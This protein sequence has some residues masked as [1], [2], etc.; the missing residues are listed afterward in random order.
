MDLSCSGYYI[1]TQ[2]KAQIVISMLCIDPSAL[3]S[4]IFSTLRAY[5]QLCRR[6]RHVHFAQKIS[7]LY[8]P[9]LFQ[10]THVLL[11]TP[12]QTSLLS[13]SACRIVTRTPST[14]THL[15][16]VAHPHDCVKPKLQ[17][18][19]NGIRLERS[20]RRF[21]SLLAQ[22]RLL[23]L[24]ATKK[25]LRRLVLIGHSQSLGEMGRM[26]SLSTGSVL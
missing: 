14:H 20:H 25:P 6:A 24:I 9:C 13:R 23:P 10:H 21:A 26:C 7:C 15:G 22:H 11:S 17:P 1:C 12:P 3:H 4:L 16:S 8:T 5:S 18:G 19:A 2:R